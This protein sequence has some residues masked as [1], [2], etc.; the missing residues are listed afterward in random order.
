MITLKE[1][2]QAAES[3]YEKMVS[4]NENETRDGYKFDLKSIDRV[5]RMIKGFREQMRACA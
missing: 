2:L 1:R 4:H 3:L 5:W